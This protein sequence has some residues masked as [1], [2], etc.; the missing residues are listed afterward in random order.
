MGAGQVIRVGAGW[1]ET[2]VETLP[3]NYSGFAVDPA[4][5]VF[6]SGN[7]TYNPYS[8]QILEMTPSGAATV[9]AGGGPA[10]S[11]DGTGTAARFNG[12]MGVTGD[13]AGNLYVADTGNDTIRKVSPTAAVTT[14]AGMAGQAGSADGT[15]SAAGFNSPQGVAVDSA[16]NIYVA[17]TGNDTIRKITPAG[18][19][20]TLAGRRGAPRASALQQEL[21][22]TAQ[23]TSTSPTQATTRSGK[24]GRAAWSPRWPVPPARPEMRT[25]PESPPSFKVQPGSRSTAQE[26]STLP[27]RATT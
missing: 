17:D 11:S 10:G 25:A 1:Q 7:P 20:S 8:G 26:T 23:E 6:L 5:D 3:G 24:S 13:S 16:G 18:A 4:Y 14:L 12:P 27:T 21:R 2:T 15:G 9:L 19:V 22:S